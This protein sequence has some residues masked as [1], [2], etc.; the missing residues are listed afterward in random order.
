MQY[1]ELRLIWELVLAKVALIRMKVRPE[2]TCNLLL[3]RWAFNFDS[4]LVSYLE[5]FA[6]CQ[7]DPNAEVGGGMGT[8]GID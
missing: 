2:T 5:A 8:T 7:K 3:N 6:V 4:L 1:R